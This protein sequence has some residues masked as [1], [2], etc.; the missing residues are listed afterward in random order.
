[1]M[2]WISNMKNSRKTILQARAMGVPVTQFLPEWQ[3]YGRAAGS[4]R[5]RLMAKHADSLILFPG[6]RGTQDMLMETKKAGLRIFDRRK[7]F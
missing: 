2:K 6:G 4:K 1:M 5:N 7:R 3:G